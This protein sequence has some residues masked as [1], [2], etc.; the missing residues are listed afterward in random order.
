[1]D[2]L[3]IVTHHV[4]VAG[5]KQCAAYAARGQSPKTVATAAVVLVG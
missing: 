1:M 5:N 3:E 4:A 2:A